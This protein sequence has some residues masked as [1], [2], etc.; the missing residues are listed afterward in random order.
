MRPLKTVVVA[1][2][3]LLLIRPIGAQANIIYE[4]TGVCNGVVTPGIE[5]CAGQATLHVVTTD[6]YIP[7]GTFTPHFACVGVTCTPVA[8]PVLLEFLYTDANSPPFDYTLSWLFDN[9]DLTLPALQ[10][11]ESGPGEGELLTT[12]QVF[13]SHSDGSWRAAGED[14][15]PNC[16]AGNPPSNNPFC[17]YGAR[18]INGTWTRIPE[19]ST[20]VLL[21]VGLVGLMIGRGRRSKT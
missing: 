1:V 9:G 17:G 5:G 21:G 10:P 3:F 19:P 4:W 20:L 11:G 2:T 6:D 15:A 8:T 12:A 18:G 14:R 13:F 7:G 16:D